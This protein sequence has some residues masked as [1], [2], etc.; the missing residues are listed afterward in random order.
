MMQRIL[1]AI[2]VLPLLVLSFAVVSE[3][4]DLAKL[5]AGQS[6][7]LK[8]DEAF[9][10]NIDVVD[11]EI[12]VRFDIADG[13]YMYRSRFN[14]DADGAILQPAIIPGGKEKTDEYL[15]DVEVYY[16]SIEI[17]V[18][19]QAQR[20]PFKFIYGFQ[21]CAD[22]GLCY[23]PQTREIELTAATVSDGQ[24]ADNTSANNAVGSGG[25]VSEQE[26]VNS[27]LADKPLWEI[28]AVMIA[29]GIGLAFTPCVLPMVP[30]LSSIIVGQGKNITSGKAF[31][32]SLTYTQ[33]MAI[34]YTLMG[35][36]VGAAGQGLSNTLQEPI[37]IIPAAIIF[38][39]LA[40]SMFGFY[41]LQLPSGLQNRLNQWSNSQQG[42]SYMGAAI[43]GFLSALVVSPCVTA[44]LAGVL[45]YIG[46]TGDW[47]IGGTAL[48]ALAVGMGIPLILVGV[49]GGKLLPK[50]GP[51]MN[52]VKA[53]FGVGLL[54][55]ALYISKHLIPGPLY[56]IAWSLLLIVPAVYLGAFSA[57]ESGGQKFWKGIGV[58]MFVYG[59][60]L[61]LG[62]AT[63]GD[64]LLK[65][66]Q[67]FTLSSAQ[68]D[69]KT[70]K[71]FDV[72]A[73]FER[74]KTIKDVEAVLARAKAEGKTVM[75]D[76]FA[77]SC[78][79]CYEFAEK[80]FPKPEVKAALANTILIQADVT[81]NDADDVALME[82][83]GV[84]GL[85]S[86]LFFDKNGVEQKHLRAIG[87]E[88]AEVFAK[89]IRA[90]FGN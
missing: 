50:A 33:A 34:P 20:S 67:G 10:A 56:L 27:L 13:Y 75:F 41:E 49:G 90:A 87:F 11:K 1:R 26:Q 31:T 82:H 81:A 25:F 38:V 88:E 86:I 51:W 28:I 39:L 77:E 43:M 57:V 36:A 60:I 29:I 12:I 6:D 42:G 5:F 85:P 80:T 16:H 35:I 15:G 40:L 46:Q 4:N 76:F 79:A 89:R 24:L 45:I 7:F 23:P 72:H 70:G 68:G 61:M 14:F 52:A 55:M 84:L 53:A 30:I 63:G 44:P 69:E 71:S 9:V 58:A 66:L 83:Y 74:V 64:S 37:F 78:T 17:A 32:L 18:P 2:F 62:A 8:V 22:K 48:Y 21:G 59:V 65:P 3:E 47:V 19:Y 54:M 73:G